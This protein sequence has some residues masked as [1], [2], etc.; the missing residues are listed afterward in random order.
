MKTRIYELETKSMIKKIPET[1][2]GTTIGLLAKTN[3]IKDKKGD[4]VRLPQYCV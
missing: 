4:L 2:T 3:M 1:C